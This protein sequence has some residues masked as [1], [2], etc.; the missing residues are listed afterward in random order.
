[1]IQK[2]GK[3]KKKKKQGKKKKVDDIWDVALISNRFY[4][5][6]RPFQ[7]KIFA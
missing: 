4:D 2:G 3:K 6:S 5:Q 1:M 7:S